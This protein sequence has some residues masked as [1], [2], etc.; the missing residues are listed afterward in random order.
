MKM[1]FNIDNE[2]FIC[3]CSIEYKDKVFTGIAFCAPSDKDMFSKRTGTQLAQAR[4][5]IKYLKYKKEEKK[6]EI[7]SVN[8]ILSCL[9]QS[10]KLDKTEKSYKMIK[11]QYHILNG[12]LNYIENAIISR[13]NWCEYTIKAKEVV[14]Q[15]IRENRSKNNK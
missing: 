14:Y 7:R 9:D 15:T 13:Q 11:R 12:E 10:N 4:A 5:E 3:S 6:S 2:R 8:H 1:N